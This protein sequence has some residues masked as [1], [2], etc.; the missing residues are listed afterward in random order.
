MAD[1][2]FKKEELEAS[3]RRA[4]V[5]KRFESILMDGHEARN[6]FLRQGIHHGIDEGL[7]YI[8][9]E[10]NESQYTAINYA[11]TKKGKRYFGLIK[12]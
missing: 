12:N 9:S 7:L 8:E 5:D 6:S 2:K 4:F 10:V 11:L 1:K 3:L